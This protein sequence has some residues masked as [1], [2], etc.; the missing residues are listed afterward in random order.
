MG[1]LKFA[2][3]D[4]KFGGCKETSKDVCN[5]HFIFSIKK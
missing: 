5:F 1:S 4:W 2:A 3:S